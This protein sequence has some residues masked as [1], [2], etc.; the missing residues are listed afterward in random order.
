M[1]AEKWQSIP[2]FLGLYEA[3]SLG[4]IRSLDRYSK[5]GKGMGWRKG[6]VLRQSVHHSGYMQVGL[7]R[8]GKLSNFLAHSLVMLTFQGP[9]PEGQ[10]VC[11]ADG[12][13]QNN[14][15]SNLR[16]DTRIGNAADK[17]K[18]LTNNAGDTNPRALLTEAQVLEIY[19]RCCAGEEQVGIASQMGVSQVTV[20]HI[21]T[22]RTWRC[23]TGKTWS[24]RHVVVDAKKVR[25]IHELQDAGRTLGQI[26]DELGISPSTAFR[27]SKR[28]SG[29]LSTVEGSLRGA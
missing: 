26:A 7:C 15:K 19:A 9:R 6:K 21:A 16:Y 4:R 12:D 17:I 18:H 13:R 29:G 24:R 2:G 3:S 14:A 23:S 22:G 25:Q 1:T 11:H 20:N 27:H 28:K 5:I 10:E 8:E